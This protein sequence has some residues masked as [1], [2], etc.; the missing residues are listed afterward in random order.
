MTIISRFYSEVSVGKA[1]ECWNWNAN[2]RSG[3]GRF[4][5]GK[6]LY[7]AHRFSLELIGIRV[8][9][10]LI[11]CHRCDNRSCVN[12]SHLFVGTK[13]DNMQDCL[14][15]GRYRNHNSEKTHCF[16]GHKFDEANVIGELV[17]GKMRRRCRTCTNE[18]QNSRRRRLMTYKV[19]T[20]VDKT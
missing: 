19:M 3:Y 2:K 16:N 9:D 10:H 14:E 7:S 18:K 20:E 5:K 12:P 8:P 1:D 11:V 4:K 13:Q 15:K 17:N 6:K